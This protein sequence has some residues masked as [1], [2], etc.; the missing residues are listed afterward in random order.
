MKERREC[1][2]DREGKCLSCSLLFFVVLFFV[3][4]L[5]RGGEPSRSASRFAVRRLSMVTW[6][7]TARRVSLQWEQQCSW[8]LSGACSARGAKR[9]S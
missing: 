3:V 1:V 7:H 2:R 5:R 6:S 9:S 8:W 4:R